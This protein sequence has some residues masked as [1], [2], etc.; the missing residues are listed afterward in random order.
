MTFDAE[1]RMVFPILLLMFSASSR[2][3]QAGSVLKSAYDRQIDS[4]GEGF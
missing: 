3:F 1:E 2:A 4:P